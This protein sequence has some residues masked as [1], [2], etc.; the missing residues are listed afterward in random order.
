MER[1]S[2]F[3]AEPNRPCSL[4][5]ADPANPEDPTA[6]GLTELGEYYNSY[7]HARGDKAA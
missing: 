3:F 7:V 5:F 4:T 6:V 2:W 1:Y